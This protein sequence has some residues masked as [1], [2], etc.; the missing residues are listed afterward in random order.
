M[1]MREV[2]E[3]SPSTPD[4]LFIA[5]QEWEK[6]NI[7]NALEMQAQWS[8]GHPEDAIAALALADSYT[9]INQLQKAIVT[10]QRILE[11]DSTN[12][13]ALNQLA[14][15]LRNVSPKE[16]LPYAQKAS[17]FAP[18]SAV[19]LDTLAMVLLENGDV[20]LANRTIQRALAQY[21]SSS[22][23][24]YHSALID[25]AAGQKTLAK[26]TLIKILA[27]TNDFPERASAEELLNK[28]ESGK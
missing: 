21:P 23:L 10:Y 16:A 5:N 14:W 19:V 9:R 26:E 12:L 13:F 3:T 17:E 20:A 7:E 24:R 25:D 11:K 15:N 8:T 28:I 1:L 2:F 6:G 4:M 18:Q 27:E 22:T